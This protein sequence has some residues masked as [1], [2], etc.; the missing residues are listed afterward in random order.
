MRCKD[1]WKH[2]L[3]YY[4]CGWVSVRASM[5]VVWAIKKFNKRTG[6][7]LKGTICGDL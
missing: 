5:C 3:V 6:I 7:T 1:G 2:W 4:I